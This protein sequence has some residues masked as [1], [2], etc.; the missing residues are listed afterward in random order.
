MDKKFLIF[1]LIFFSFNNF[2]FAQE[3][4]GIDENELL[5]EIPGMVKEIKTNQQKKTNI[6]NRKEGA[7]K[8]PSE[9]PK[10]TSL[11]T[12]G[13]IKR[14]LIRSS[15]EGIRYLS[16]PSI[17]LKDG[18]YRLDLKSNNLY[19][20]DGDAFWTLKGWHSMLLGFQAAPA[21]NIEGYFQLAI[22]ADNPAAAEINARPWWVGTRHFALY[23]I[24]T[25]TG[26]YIR[27]YTGGNLGTDEAL[28][29]HVHDLEAA[30][31][32]DTDTVGVFIK[33]VDAQ[34]DTEYFRLNIFKNIGHPGWDELFRLYW[35]N[36]E[37]ER[38][39]ESGH[40]VPEGVKIEGKEFLSPLTL[41]FGE[42]PLWGEDPMFIG[43]LSYPLE[44]F[45]TLSLIHR[46]ILTDI[47]DE[48][49]V[50]YL[51]PNVPRADY[52]NKVFIAIP[53]STNKTRGIFDADNRITALDVKYKIKII[54]L[55]AEFAKYKPRR[56]SL[57]YG[58]RAKSD[59]SLLMNLDF[60]FN[61]D[62]KF[63]HQDKFAGNRN[64]FDLI[65]HIRPVNDILFILG[66]Q[67][68]K[69]VSGDVEWVFPPLILDAESLTWLNNRER[70]GFEIAFI[71]DPTP[72]TWFRL[73]NINEIETADIA[74][75]I[76]YQII[77]YPTYTDYQEHYDY[78]WR[79]WWQEKHQDT[80]RGESVYTYGKYPYKKDNFKFK[81]ISN[82]LK[83]FKI[84]L[85][86]NTAL[87]EAGVGS[88]YALTPFT[89]NYTAYSEI[90]YKN[91]LIFGFLYAKDD[92]G[93]ALGHDEWGIKYDRRV[94]LSLK[95]K[96]GTSY[97]ETYYE[98]ALN[99]NVET[100][101]RAYG[102]S[103][104]MSYKELGMVFLIKF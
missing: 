75:E 23:V 68:I 31:L 53:A 20:R 44:D 79:V 29:L 14:V 37:V 49:G 5:P 27:D 103:P 58:I 9:P 33:K 101:G 84:I 17:T 4:L 94:R 46:E 30:G 19:K 34:I 38:Y 6:T 56:E 86:F 91:E 67:I 21:N 80:I 26:E 18:E 104:D 98:D 73:W 15:Q 7:I 54:M 77:D 57:A 2:I 83:P 10:D 92:W 13:M 35:E 78:E 41:I 100:T 102:L 64:K 82:Y 93:P 70:Q 89:I 48:E 71:Y 36:W 61:L 87:K 3:D 8:K 66:Y 60:G 12:E 55:E 1:T 99:R 63:I 76:A 11:D 74:F 28:G 40:F 43:K 72:A 45:L 85:D 42:E 22:Y 16:K 69:P 51:I 90:W 62:L 24:D 50:I 96:I 39:E 52:E 65:S 88:R 32:Y 59:L 25:E 97:I 81:L 95:Y 47:S